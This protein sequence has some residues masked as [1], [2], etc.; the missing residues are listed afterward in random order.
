MFSLNPRVFFRIGAGLFCL[1][2]LFVI[3]GCSEDVTPNKTFH[4]DVQLFTQK[5]VNDFGAKKYTKIG[6]DLVIGGEEYDEYDPSDITDLTPLE[7]LKT[8]NGDLLITRAWLLRSLHGL[9][10]LGYCK[11]FTIDFN[12][13]ETIALP[14]LTEIYGDLEIRGPSITLVDFANLITIS[15]KLDLYDLKIKDLQG[16]KNLSSIGDASDDPRSLGVLRI[17]EN[18]Y[19]QS[20]A[21]LE[22]LEKMSFYPSIEIYSNDSL[23]SIYGLSGI[24]ASPNLRVVGNKSLKSLEGLE[25][26]TSIIS[27]LLVGGNESLTSLDGLQN[28]SSMTHDITSQFVPIIRFEWNDKLLDFCAISPLIDALNNNNFTYRFELNSNAY[29]PTAQE[30]V[31]G[32]CKQ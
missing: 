7:N 16:F 8:I 23:E 13:L 22:N 30:I 26:I 5:E 19:L 17:K 32:D 4:G 11:D 28:I 6:G 18:H 29:N 12:Y 25:G 21:G 27:S 15:G 24:K 20:L 9:Q 10:N 14:N 1:G 31:D 2:L 3:L